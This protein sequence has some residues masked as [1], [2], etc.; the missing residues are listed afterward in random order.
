MG[1][2]R[3]ARGPVR[4]GP[5]RPLQALCDGGFKAQQGLRAGAAAPGLG[6]FDARLNRCG[7]RPCH[8]RPRHPQTRGKVER[9]HGSGHRELTYFDARRPHEAIGDVPPVTRWRP[10][11]RPRPAALPEAESFYPPGSELRRVGASGDVRGRVLCGRGIT[12]QHVRPERRAR[13]VAIFYCRT[14]IRRLPHDALA[15]DKML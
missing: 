5:R 8:G 9:L 10:G 15:G 13:E 14:E 2:A 3:R 6:W 4:A 1:G 7:V 12:G 11:D